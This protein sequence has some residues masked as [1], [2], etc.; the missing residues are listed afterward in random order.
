MKVIFSNMKSTKS[1]T[2]Y[3]IPLVHNAYAIQYSDMLISSTKIATPVR[4]NHG[5]HLKAC[6]P[7]LIK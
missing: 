6:T 4:W 5:L 2:Q 1:G 7:Q 3:Y